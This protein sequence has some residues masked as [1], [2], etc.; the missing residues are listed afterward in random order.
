[1]TDNYHINIRQLLCTCAATE[2]TINQI[3][4]GTPASTINL[5]QPAKSD[6]GVVLMELFYVCLDEVLVLQVFPDDYCI[7]Y[8]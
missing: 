5:K 2:G 1:M 7:L 6:L 3:T 4:R 8:S